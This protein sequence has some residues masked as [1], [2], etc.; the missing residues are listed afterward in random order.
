MD[1]LLCK[2]STIRKTAKVLD[3]LGN[4]LMEIELSTNLFLKSFL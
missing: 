2:I 4:T 3:F 1:H